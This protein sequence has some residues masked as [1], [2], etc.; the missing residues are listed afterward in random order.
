MTNHG[1]GPAKIAGFSF[2]V[3]GV[4]RTLRS[5]AQ[6]QALADDLQIAA[7]FEKVAEIAI[8]GMIAPGQTRQVIHLTGI[9]VPEDEDLRATLRRISV[10]IQYRS[11]FDELM[12]VENADDKEA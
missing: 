10:A 6:I 2:M 7:T 5:D 3:D 11:L 4:A 9:V 12:P 1:L 8:G